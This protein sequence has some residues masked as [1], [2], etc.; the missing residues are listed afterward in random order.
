M[1][2]LA[3]GAASPWAF[4]AHP[5]VWALVIALSSGY[6]L[7]LRFLAPGR[8]PV[9]RPPAS[10]R[11]QLAFFAGVATLW[12]G[13]DWPIHDISEG[14]LFS[15]HMVQHLLFTF[16]APPL[17]LLGMPPWLLRAV[18]PKGRGMAIVRFFT[19]PLVALLLFNAVIAITHWPSL[20][21]L[22][23]RVELVHFAIHS[24]L[25][26]TATLMWWPVVAPL[27]ELA[28]L[29]PPAKM[30]YLFLQSILPTV[31]ASFLTFASTPIYR[32][33]A[34]VP[35]VWSWLDVVTDQRIAG[36]I[37][38]LGGGLLLW[39]VIAFLFFRWSRAE[40]GEGEPELSWDDFERELQAW[41]MRR[42]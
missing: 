32:F 17:L 10:V 37:M 15:V 16:V 23:L 34:S 9:G 11:Q 36:L 41:D 25:F 28:R 22:S 35:R 24:V 1:T 21:D 5:D 13:A 2:P 39:S 26:V 14:Y 20:V 6:A 40:E 29:S 4:H 18:L 42:S 3:A 33:Y 31:P 30:L 38:K 12:I 7:A 27:P 8:A 19:R